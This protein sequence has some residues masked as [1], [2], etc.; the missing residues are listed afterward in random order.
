MQSFATRIANKPAN[1]PIVVQPPHTQMIRGKPTQLTMASG[2]PHQPR[3]LGFAQPQTLETVKSVGKTVHNLVT[4]ELF[5]DV[6]LLK[7]TGFAQIFSIVRSVRMA[8]DNFC[9]AGLF[10]CTYIYISM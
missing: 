7:V 4:T 5:A 10:S 3:M 6:W 1:R 9:H 2:A 8:T